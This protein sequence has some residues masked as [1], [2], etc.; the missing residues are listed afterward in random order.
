MGGCDIG[1]VSMVLM[2]GWGGVHGFVG[3]VCLMSSCSSSGLLFSAGI[4][5]V[6]GSVMCAWLDAY[7]FMEV[8]FLLFPG[9]LVSSVCACSPPSVVSVVYTDWC[10]MCMGPLYSL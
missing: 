9:V 1:V 7:G 8:V 4:F 6:Q 10:C 2:L 5:C 3:L